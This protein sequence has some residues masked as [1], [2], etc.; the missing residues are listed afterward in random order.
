MIAIRTLYARDLSSVCLHEIW[1]CRKG[2][3]EVVF[4]GAALA[5]AQHAT[6]KSP[7]PT[8]DKSSPKIPPRIVGSKRKFVEDQSTYSNSINPAR[9]KAKLPF[10]LCS[11]VMH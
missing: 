3:H 9:K 7:P 2:V 11:T 8:K 4:V 5:I 6:E 10:V 1:Y